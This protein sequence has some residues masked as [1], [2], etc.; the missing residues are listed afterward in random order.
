MVGKDI[1]ERNAIL[2]AVHAHDVLD[3]PGVVLALFVQIALDGEGNPEAE[4]EKR[5]PTTKLSSAGLVYKYYGKEVIK[6]MCKSFYDLDLNEEQIDKLYEKIYKSL[7]MEIDAIDNGVD[8]AD[9]T[10]YNI[11]TNLSSRIGNY[12]SPWNAPSDA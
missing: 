2:L 1:F 5:E 7:I 9:S 4:S 3:E 10:K 8:Q 12:N 6:T 11:T